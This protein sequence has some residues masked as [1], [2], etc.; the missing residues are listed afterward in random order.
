MEVETGTS[1]QP[2][3]YL[4]MFMGGVVVHN[5]VKVQVPRSLAVKEA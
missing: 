3:F 4:F 1:D 5:Q 2:F